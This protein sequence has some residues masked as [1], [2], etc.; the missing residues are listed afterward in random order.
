MGILLG[1]RAK[2]AP[3]ASGDLFIG[4]VLPVI[5][6]L[7]H[8]VRV[9]GY[10]YFRD[11]LYYLACAEHLDFGYVDHPP[12][13]ALV[14][15]GVRALLG[16]SLFALRLLPALAAGATVALAVALVRELGGG[17]FARA[18]A[19]VATLL[20]PVY[21]GLF[22]ILSMNAFDVLFW[23]VDWWLLARLLRTG[24][25]RL[26]LAFGAVTGLA[27]ENKIS[28][29]VLGFGLVVGLILGGAWEPFRSR[30]LWLGG[31][32]A[33]L[34]ALPHLIWQI[35]H[36]WPTLEFMRNAQEQKI[37]AL[38]PPAFMGQQ[39]LLAGA[40]SL[41]VW[42]AGL[43]FLLLSR[44]GR[45]YRPLGWACLAIL[46][47]MMATKSKPYYL[48]P[49]FTILFAG[50][51]TMI[52]AWIARLGAA[53]G[54]ADAARGESA[55]V[56]S[57]AAARGVLLAI[58]TAG[59]LLTAP[60]ARPLLPLRVYVRYAAWLGIK[61]SSGERHEMGRLPQMFADMRGWPELAETVAGVFRNLSPDERRVACIFGQN[62]GQAGAIDLFGPALGLPKAICAR[63]SYFLWGPRDCT[64]DVLIV[65][66][67][68][69]GTL[70][71]L[72]ASVDR[73]ATYVCDD[74]MPYENHKPIWVA[75]GLKRPLV[76]LWPAIRKYI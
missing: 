17:R 57:A 54:S 51:S 13:I 7:L 58:V 47:V 16:P 36:G 72:F 52:E 21:L 29:L 74:C 45:P 19:A 18:L 6:V 71:T 8:L 59:G 66:G 76:D 61:A 73:G 14:T 39:V 75:R 34:L 32:L 15:A 68:D 28:V 31:A 70:E 26:W 44:R 35:V 9:G 24:D 3:P 42:I 1:D 5:A 50:G 37:L 48:S 41:P 23:A 10:G 46:A 62:Y 22:S 40:L 56:R 2:P 27:L 25:Q 11:E 12:L 30:R 63:N 4:R 55:T 38:S 67:D 53:A 65:I 43:I 60:L 64:G 20:A 49:V 69:R 33:G